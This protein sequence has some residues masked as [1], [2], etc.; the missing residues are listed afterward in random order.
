MFQKLFSRRGA[1]ALATVALGMSGMSLAFA[2]TAGAADTLPNASLLVGSGSN[3]AYSLM[4]AEGNLFNTAPGCDLTISGESDPVNMNCGTA[5]EAP[6]DAQTN[7]NAGENGFTQANENPYDDY[8]VQAPAVGSGSGVNQL[9]NTVAGGFEPNYARSSGAPSASNGTSQQNYEAYAVDGVSWSA[10]KDK[11][12]KSGTKTTTTLYP[13]NYVQTITPG[14]IAD[15][16]QGTLAGCTKEVGTSSSHTNKTIS[17]MNWACLDTSTLLSTTVYAVVNKPIDCYIPQ[18]GSGTAGTWA[19]D[20]GYSKSMTT[21]DCLA[22]EA[23]GT[24]ASHINLFENEMAEIAEGTVNGV[25]NND[26]P[27]AIYFFSYGKFKA[28]C[29]AITAAKT[30]P[31]TAIT[32]QCA[33][34]TKGSGTTQYVTQLGD[35]NNPVSNAPQSPTQ[36][37]IQAAVAD[38]LVSSS[39]FDVTRYLYNVYNNST[40]TGTQAGSANQATLNLVSEYGFLCK[41]GTVGDYDP[42]TGV[43]YRTEIEANIKTQGFYPL[44]T[45]DL[46]PF[47]EGSLNDPATISDSFYSS[48]DPTLT[49]E[50]GTGPGSATTRGNGIPTT[51]TNSPSDPYGFCL[52]FNG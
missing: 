28:T 4:V 45:S 10:F 36:A 12:V 29:K 31:V 16:W 25:A 40:A 43:N 2:G 46:K 20:F 41:P 35:I 32:G 33:G 11:A 5:P 51:E 42:I 26:Q 52:S 38:G 47:K 8:T 37:N 44:D 17:A 22:D 50:V 21:G 48:V 39:T 24:A 30:S 6:G 14:D 7:P 9:K 1:V 18:A 27:N 49:A 34:T 3:T 13:S 23:H 15:I 19:G